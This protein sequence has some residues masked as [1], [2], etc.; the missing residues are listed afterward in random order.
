MPWWRDAV[1]AGFNTGAEPWLPLGADH[2]QRAVDVQES[3]PA[4]V[5]ARARALLAWRRREAVLR[6]GEI[7]FHHAPGQHALLFERLLPGQAPLVLAFNLGGRALD[8]PCRTPWGLSALPG[9]PLPM[10]QLSP[11]GRGWHLPPHSAAVATR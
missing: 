6:Q 1:N 4:S 8:I 11:D 5:L 2:A 3:N 10:A 7:R 9:T